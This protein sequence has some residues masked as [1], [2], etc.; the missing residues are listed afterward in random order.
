MI[1]EHSNEEN[2]KVLSKYRKGNLEKW[3]GGCIYTMAPPAAPHLSP[4]LK[5]SQPFSS[6]WHSAATH[7]FT[8]APPSSLWHSGQ[9]VLSCL[10][11]PPH[12]PVRKAAASKC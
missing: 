12:L 10:L 7:S 4:G 3:R 6:T 5:G 11:P 8:P 2:H 9:A 1:M